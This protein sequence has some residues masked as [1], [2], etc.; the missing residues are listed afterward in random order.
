VTRDVTTHSTP[1]FIIPAVNAESEIDDDHFQ[2]YIESGLDGD[3]IGFDDYVCDQDDDN[4][5]AKSGTYNA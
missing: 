3:G 2:D 4:P 1:R 5:E